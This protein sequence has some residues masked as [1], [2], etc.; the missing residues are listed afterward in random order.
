[1]SE[2]TPGGTAVNGSQSTGELVKQLSEQAAT[3]V[4][5]EI[6]LAKAEM[7]QKGREAGRAAGMFSVTGLF[8]L[9]GFALLTTMLVLAL[10]GPVADWLA[11]LIVAAVYL[12]IAAVSGLR[13]RDRLR[14]AT[15]IAPEQTIETLKEDAQWAKNQPTSDAR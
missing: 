5:Q 13:G 15:P 7:T 10:E 8:G 14:E 6:D 3:L 11:A 12:A 9:A 4:R 2:H 1:M